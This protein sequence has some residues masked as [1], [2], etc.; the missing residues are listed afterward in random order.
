MMDSNDFHRLSFDSYILP[1]TELKP[2]E[3]R[4]IEVDNQT[5]LPI[6]IPIRICFQMGIVLSIFGGKM[7][8]KIF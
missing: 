2:G 5:I 3:L 7:V 4:L 1:T 6:E 8:G